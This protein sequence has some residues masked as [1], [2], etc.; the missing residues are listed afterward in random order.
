MKSDQQL[1]HSH[2]DSVSSGVLSS[3]TDTP[4]P[5][6]LSVDA[7]TAVTVEV[8]GA[9]VVISATGVRIQRHAAATVELPARTDVPL[10]Q[11]RGCSEIPATTTLPG[12]FVL[13]LSGQEPISALSARRYAYAI[14]FTTHHQSQR[15]ILHDALQ[16]MQAGDKDRLRHLAKLSGT[17]LSNV[18][19]AADSA[20]TSTTDA[21]PA[22]AATDSADAAHSSQAA[23]FEF[24]AFDVETANQEKGSICQIGAV[25]VRGREVVAKKVW[26]CQP[27]QKFGAFD[28]ANVEIHGITADDVAEAPPFAECAKEFLDFAGDMPLVAHNARFD[29]QA[30]VNAAQADG[31]KL[32]NH[33]FFCTYL[34]ARK[35]WHDCENYKLP[36]VAA[37]AGFDL[38]SH[39]DALADSL[40]CA[41]I[42]MALAEGADSLADINR[43]LSLT[44]GAITNGRIEYVQ[45]KQGDTSISAEVSAQPV[46][47]RRTVKAPE[48]IPETNTNANPDGLLYGQRV[49]LT[50][51]FD[52]HSKGE[53]WQLIADVGGYVN[54]SVTKKTTIVVCGEWKS[55][56]SKEK[57]ARQLQEEGQQIDIWDR[58]QLYKVLGID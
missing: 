24:V 3:A 28:P 26:L 8:L 45:N 56:T 11:I 43:S 52:D 32:G 12:A 39:H 13:L 44:A 42:M 33:Q 22:I 21:S 47:M 55:M 27:P 51:E 57:K 30:M 50:G 1:T 38:T 34:G 31:L 49:T 15:D 54:K 40:A 5:E 48:T 58:F 36:T 7:D 29:T 35:K 20:T 6:P 25:R 10:S 53:I 18:S 2:H 9:Y 4:I 17:D 19:A 37:H 46:W 14:R 23:S 41:H 16:A